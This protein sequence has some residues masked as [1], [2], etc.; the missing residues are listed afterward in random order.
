MMTPVQYDRMNAI[1]RVRSHEE[2]RPGTHVPSTTT[3][4]VPIT[5][6]VGH[7]CL[8]AFNA[9]LWTSCPMRT[10]SSEKWMVRAVSCP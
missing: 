5:S 10:F 3:F 9:M 7:D 2:D 1:T 6:T 4:H 8:L